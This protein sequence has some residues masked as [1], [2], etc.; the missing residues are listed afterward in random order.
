MTE[1]VLQK[2]I[3]KFSNRKDRFSVNISYIDISSDSFNAF[4]EK[5]LQ[6][7]TIGEQM[8]FE[9][10][11]SDSIEDYERVNQ[12][13]SHVK[14]YGVTIAID[15]FGSGYSNFMHLTKLN[16]DYI[17]IDGSIIKDIDH[18]EKALIVTETIVEFARM[19]K[20][21]VVAEFVHNE[22]VYNRVKELDIDG[23]QGFYLAKPNADPL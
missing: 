19:M 11:E 1:I 18:D 15:D 4:L 5:Q 20:M 23:F 9:I 17:K 8:I 14:S 21:G 6:K 22:E 2:A 13:M 16:A 7:S 3:Q 10:L 12:F